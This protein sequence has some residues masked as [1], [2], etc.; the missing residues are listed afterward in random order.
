MQITQIKST[1]IAADVALNEMKGL[2]ILPPN[3]CLHKQ[4]MGVRMTY[5]WTSGFLSVVISD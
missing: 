5:P 2:E 1:Q 3:A 4:T